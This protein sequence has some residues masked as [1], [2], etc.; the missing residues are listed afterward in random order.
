MGCQGK[1]GVTAFSAPPLCFPLQSCLPCL[2]KFSLG[3]FWLQVLLFNYG[4]LCHMISPRPPGIIKTFQSYLTLWITEYHMVVVIGK[5]LLKHFQNFQSFHC[6]FGDPCSLKVSEIF[7][8]Q[9]FSMA[10]DLW[11]AFCF[12]L[13]IYFFGKT[14]L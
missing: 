13:F 10:I 9:V 8:K 3:G 12:Y 2:V 5:K 11:Q 14:T 1:T 7:L 6:Q 4:L